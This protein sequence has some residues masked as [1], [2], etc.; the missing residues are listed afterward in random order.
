MKSKNLLAFIGIFAVLFLSLSLVSAAVEYNPAELTGTEDSGQTVNLDLT[1]SNTYAGDLSNMNV[2]FSDLVSGSNTISDNN[3]EIPLINSSTVI[4]GDESLDVVLT[5]QIPS[6]QEVGTYTGD[7]ELFASVGAG[8]PLSRGKVD[9][10]LE[11]TEVEQ[12]EPEQDSFCKNGATDDSDLTFNVEIKNK[13]AGDEDDEWLPLDKIEV[14]VELE[15]DKT[16]DLSDVVFEIGLFKE[17]SPAASNIIDDMF[18]ISEDDEEIEIGDVD[19]DESEK[20]TFIFRVDPEIEDSDYILKVKAYPD[21]KESDTCIDHSGD[22][23]EWGAED[24]YAEIKIDREDIN[25]ERAVIVDVSEIDLPY[26]V[27][28]DQSVTITAD[29]YNIADEDQEQVKVILENSE[30]GINLEKEIREDIDGGEK[31]TISFN[32]NIPSNAAQKEYTLEFRTYY[33][34]DEDDGTYDEASEVFTHRL[35][36]IGNCAAGS[37]GVQTSEPTITASLLS[38][39]LVGKELIVQVSVVN[40]MDAEGNFVISTQNTAAWA[41]SVNVDPQI[42]TIAQGS[43]KQATVT[44][45]PNQAGTQTFDITLSYNGNQATETVQ[46]SIAEQTGFMTGAFSGLGMGSTGLYVISGV[47]LVLIILIL[48]LIVKVARAPKVSDF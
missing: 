12:P 22:L 29:L 28:C 42:L 10:T 21:G 36:V 41:E 4:T 27:P 25:D 35:K 8:D 19:E 24:F 26:E 31:E 33:D 2:V 15:N 7:L 48:V 9:I 13:G 47:F 6:S 39:A 16:S 32:F 46:V 23:D 34:Y 1:I 44:L 30:L 18:W 17:G 45:K 3:L 5:I 14:E 11:V 43:A 20:H 40:N 37:G 38:D